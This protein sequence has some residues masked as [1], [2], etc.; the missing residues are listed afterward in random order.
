MYQQCLIM[1]N[2]GKDPEMRYTAS[3][4]AV[5][6]FNVAVNHRN[7]EDGEWKDKTTW[8]RVTCWDR[9]AET[10]NQYLKKGSKVFVVGRIDISTWADKQSGEARGQLE[11]TAREVKFL[12]GKEDGGEASSPTAPAHSEEDIPF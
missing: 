7:Q 3:G 9:L 11:L 6:T 5:T 1:G 2:L 8:F 4:K 12:S 10:T